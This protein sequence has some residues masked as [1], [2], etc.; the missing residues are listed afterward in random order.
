MAALGIAKRQVLSFTRL[1]YGYF[2]YLQGDLSLSYGKCNFYDSSKKIYH[3][4]CSTTGKLELIC[5][6]RLDNRDKQETFT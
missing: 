3:I 6:D 4:R 2:N 5:A 1:L